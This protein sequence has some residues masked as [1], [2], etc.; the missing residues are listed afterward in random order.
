[1]AKASEGK[2]Q[3]VVEPAATP[4]AGSRGITLKHVAQAAGV[5]YST[6]SRAL[7]PNKQSL[8]SEATLAH[9]QETARRLGYQH[10][11]LA[12]SL[13]RQRSDTIGIVIPDLANP[14]WGPILHA[15]HR[16]CDER[17][18]VPLIGE[19]HGERRSHRELLERLAGWRVGAIISGAARL[20]DQAMLERF[21]RTQ[22]PVLLMV[23]ATLDGLPRVVDDGA[24]G[25]ELAVKHLAALR[26]RRIAQLAGPQHTYSFFVRRLGFLEQ[27]A[28][29][30]VAVIDVGQC[31]VA[32][33]YEEGH[34][35]MNA[36]LR[37]R[38]RPTAVFAHN[39]LMAIGAIDAL[40]EADL[41]CPDDVSVIGYNDFPLVDH[42]SPALSTLRVPADELGYSAG[43]MAVDLIENPD[44]TPAS[45]SLAPQLIARQSTAP[46]PRRRRT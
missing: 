36:A 6:A 42:I 43:T 2:S 29:S 33:T 3:V 39:D 12:R 32:P 44:Q 7:D 9:V 11:M 19:T 20:D 31:G 18:Y 4:M 27:A 24:L 23:R 8:V 15:I 45:V 5:H 26:H 17:G 35:L 13:R 34:R 16:A 41:V 46:P 40:R 1:M 38:R 22:V 14:F 25:A 10:H 21:V 28:A 30:E 37:L